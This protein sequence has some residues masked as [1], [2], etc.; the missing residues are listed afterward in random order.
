MAPAPVVR[1]SML[2]SRPYEVTLLRMRSC[3]A[4]VFA[5]VTATPTLGQAPYIMVIVYHNDL[6]S[7]VFMSINRFSNG[8][9][10]EE[11]DT[12]LG[13]VLTAVAAAA[14]MFAA[15]VDVL[16]IAAY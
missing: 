1:L 8:S 10:D 15:F 9:I 3:S 6:P 11:I 5:T 4:S 2:R 12:A 14:A 16:V 7:L 13:A